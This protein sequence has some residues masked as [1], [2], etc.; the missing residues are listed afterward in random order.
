MSL[1]GQKTKKKKIAK[2]AHFP[3]PIPAKAQKWLKRAEG[4]QKGGKIGLK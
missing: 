3:T 4:G 1:G 2:L